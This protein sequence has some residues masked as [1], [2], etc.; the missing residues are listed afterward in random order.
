MANDT[1]TLYDLLYY[2]Q[3]GQRVAIV[4][5]RRDED[6][7]RNGL[8][9]NQPEDEAVQ[10]FISTEYD[11]GR[12][13]VITGSAG[14]GKSA[15]L[16]RATRM[17][18]G[19]VI[20]D[21]R[22]N[23]DAT[24]AVQAD[25]DYDERLIT[26]FNRIINDVRTKSGPRS[27]VA[28]NYGLAVDFFRL[29]ENG[30]RENGAFSD[31]W[32]A[33]QQSEQPNKQTDSNIEVINLSNRRTY[34]TNPEQI[35]RGLLR[36]IFNRFDPTYD[37]SPFTKAFEYEKEHCPAGERCPL[38]YNV[39]QLTKEVTKD[40]LAEFFASW[41][42]VK[43]AYLNP[44]MIIDRISRSLLPTGVR[45]LPDHEVCPVGAAVDQG[46]YSVSA[47]DLLWN[48]AFSALS[49]TDEE[50][51]FADP[52]SRTGF[53]LDQKILSWNASQQELDHALEEPHFSLTDSRQKIRTVLRKRYLTG[54][55]TSF[56][57]T[58]VAFKEY[59]GALTYYGP[60]ESEMTPE[61]RDSVKAFNAIIEEALE[62][63]TGRETEGNLVEF[64]DT[65]RSTDYQ[66]L[67]ERNP[68]NVQT[69]PSQDASRIISLPGRIKLKV[70][71][72]HEEGNTIPIPLSFP[73]YKLMRLISDG[74]IPNSADMNQSHSIQMLQTKISA[75]TQKGTFVKIR[76][77]SAD[78]S[79]TLDYDDDLGITVTSEGF[80]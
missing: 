35:G 64:R 48:A 38:H 39:N 68:P 75:L 59:V 52:A 60:Q 51:S 45:E 17:A 40:R 1:N 61:V 37:K 65:R 31:I 80:K 22:V 42:I 56:L 20:P 57:A 13:L 19:E 46:T 66:F 25:E 33:I 8:Y 44:R 69:G 72:K 32:E 23:M 9:V 73:L 53:E 4:G 41:S 74:Y 3:E 5:S 58:N 50:A 7:V 11:D 2:C 47:E 16:E 29:R 14:D 36:E 30:D 79:V 26:F 67:S 43:G 77:I 63:W 18:K 62:N 70:A 12:L 54:Q 28:I 49:T 76:N 21:K 15:L 27:A 78:R 6:E 55:G 71:P 34:K 10:E 24:S